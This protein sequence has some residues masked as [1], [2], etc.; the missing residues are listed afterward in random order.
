MQG[1]PIVNDTLESQVKALEER[2]V[3]LAR[4]H[5]IETDKKFGDI[6]INVYSTDPINVWEPTITTSQ[7]T[8]YGKYLYLTFDNGYADSNHE[9]EVRYYQESPTPSTPG[10]YVSLFTGTLPFTTITTSVF[11]QEIDLS[12]FLSQI[13]GTFGYVQ[14]W[15]RRIVGSTFTFATGKISIGGRRP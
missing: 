8:M 14:L 4:P 15:Q 6:I 7:V 9:Y 10:S 1:Y 5:D 11:V 3:A 13:E 2:V 12:S